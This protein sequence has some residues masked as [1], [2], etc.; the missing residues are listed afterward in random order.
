MIHE[1]KTHPAYF[2]R[3]A[4]GSKTFEIR[5]NDRGYQ[6]GDILLLQEYNPAGMHDRCDDPEC[7]NARYTGAQIRYRVGFVASGGLFGLALGEHVV[8]SLLPCGDEYEEG[9]R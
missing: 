3:L 9:Q 5:R 2:A 7:R 6:T 4:D 8:M 1:L